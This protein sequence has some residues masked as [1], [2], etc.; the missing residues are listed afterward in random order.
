MVGWV[1][2]D[3]KVLLALISP[4]QLLRIVTYVRFACYIQKLPQ[5]CSL[6]SA[7]SPFYMRNTVNLA[8]KVLINLYDGSSW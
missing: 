1:E 4:P 6:N 7:C 5:G 8:L 3:Y 2:E